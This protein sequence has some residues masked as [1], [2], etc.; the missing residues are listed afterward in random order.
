MRYLNASVFILMLISSGADA[1]QFCF[2][3]AETYYEQVYCQLQAK[4]QTKQLPP[5]HQFKKN[6]EQ[7]QFSLLKRPAQRNGIALVAP[8][9]KSPSVPAAQAATAPADA[10][11][12]SPSH[13]APRPLHTS[14]PA[15]ATLRNNVQVNAADQCELHQSELVCG[16]V[17]YRL[18]GNRANHR[19]T[20]GVLTAANK[21]DLP[22]ST[23]R[24]YD[25][26]AAYQ[27]YIAKMCEIG[28]CGVTMSYR[29][30]AFLYQDLQI[31]GLDFAQRFETM[32]GFLKQ[33]K[34]AMAVSE[35]INSPAGLSAE[36]CSALGELYYVCDYQG[37]NLVFV[38]R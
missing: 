32:F 34:A 28:L 14:E 5:F 2:A 27:Q 16:Q 15:R 35:A 37:K 31:K 23:G 33:D 4:A 11:S 25:L 30:F 17:S 38:R 13:S 24:A 6:N 7:V 22:A 9:K 36:Y 3:A 12:V 19:L 21:M 29:K 8:S 18:T 26:A 20:A 10:I 1:N